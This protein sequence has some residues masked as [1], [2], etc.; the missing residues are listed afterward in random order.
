M[1]LV[2][3]S[4]VTRQIWKLSTFYFLCEHASIVFQWLDAAAAITSGHKKAQQLT[5]AFIQNDT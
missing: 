5:E 4:N 1:I 2:T 3:Q